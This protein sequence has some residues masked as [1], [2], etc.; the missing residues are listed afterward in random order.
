[1]K[2][3]GPVFATN[4]IIRLNISNY[5]EFLFFYGH[6]RRGGLGIRVLDN[7]QTILNGHKRNSI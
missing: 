6:L 1:M 2:D 3:P 5:L 4:Y 7:I